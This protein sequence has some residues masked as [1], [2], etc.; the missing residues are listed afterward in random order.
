MPKLPR[1][2]SREAIR[3]LERLG[4]EQVRQTGSHIVMKKETE[5]GEIGCVVPVH[6]ELKIGTLSGILK[7]AQVTVEEFIDRL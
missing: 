7:Q 6:R 5:K 3:S 1:I 2:S 4:F